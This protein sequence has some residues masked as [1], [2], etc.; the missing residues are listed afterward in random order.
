MR[1]PRA[2]IESSSEDSSRNHDGNDSEEEGDIEER[3][4]LSKRSITNTGH[5]ID[6]FIR[7]RKPRPVLSDSEDEILDSSKISHLDKEATP[8]KKVEVTDD[9]DTDED[10][11]NLSARVKNSRISQDF[12]LG[13]GKIVNSTILDTGKWKLF[14]PSLKLEF[15]TLRFFEFF[16]EADAFEK[17]M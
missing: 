9:E 12:K 1:P 3:N 16:P 10:I 8:S 5:E 13:K 17:E 2:V 6:S 15:L 11:L 7:Q 14:V 4:K